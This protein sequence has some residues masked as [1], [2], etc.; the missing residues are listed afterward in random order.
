MY[1]DFIIRIKNAQAVKQERVK[2]PFRKSDLAILEVMYSSGF[3][4]GIIKRG[5]GIKR[6]IEVTLKYEADGSPRVSAVKFISRPGRRVYVNYSS[7]RPVR[8]G[9]GLGLISTPKGI[10]TA[11][12]ARREK[13]GGEYLFQIW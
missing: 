4:G 3:I 2:L 12:N 5:R 7:L 1:G 6:L 8:Q 13:V 11:E 10:M 9:F